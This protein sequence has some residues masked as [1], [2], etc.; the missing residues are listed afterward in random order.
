M[1]LLAGRFSARSGASVQYSLFI[2]HKAGDSVE[3][4]EQIQVLLKQLQQ[5][6][7]LD[8][9]ERLDIIEAGVLAMEAGGESISEYENL[10]RNI[11]SLKGSGGTHGLQIIT[12]ICH[13][14]EDIMS[15]WDHQS[16]SFSESMVSKLLA[17]IDLLRQVPALTEGNCDYSA[18]MKQ[19]EGLRACTSVKSMHVLLVMDRTLSLA[20]TK[21]CAGLPV[22]ARVINHGLEALETLLADPFD[23][24]VTSHQLEQLNGP[25]LIAAVRISETQ[26]RNIKTVLLTSSMPLPQRGD[27][28]DYVI[29]KDDGMIAKLCVAFKEILTDQGAVR[30]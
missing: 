20:V 21:A 13:Q 19:L 25:A 15:S 14:I 26:N 5:T 4:Q 9:P 16:G 3:K 30:S 22:H 6:F 23:I 10:Y 8:L 28:A 2:Y 27:T 18:M 17:H 29:S 24:L 1:D 11:H 7:L 12:T